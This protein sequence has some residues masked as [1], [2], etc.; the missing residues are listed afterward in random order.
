MLA[1]NSVGD[2]TRQGRGAL[3]PDSNM[4]T[5]LRHCGVALTVLL[6]ATA[7]ERSEPPDVRPPEPDLHGARLVVGSSVD[8]WSLL[9][10]PQGGGLAE[11]RTLSDLSRIVWTGTTELPPAIEAHALSGGTVVLR[12]AEGVVHT[13]DPPS[14]VLIRVGEIDP[15]AVWS[16]DAT[17]GL[18]LS[19]NGSLL[20]ISADGV[21][22]YGLEREVTWAAPADG[23]V[24]VSVAEGTE[25]RALWLLQ[26]DQD[27]PVETG[28]AAVRSPGVVTAWGRRAVLTSSDGRGLAVLTVAPIELAGDVNLG[29]PIRTISTSPSTHEIYVGLD[30]PPR[31]LAVN[32]FNLS[33]RVVAELSVA[34]GAI[35][36]TLFGDGILVEQDDQVVRVPVGGGT[37]TRLGSSWRPDLP[38]GIPGPRVIT[39]RSEDVFVADLQTG[40]ETVLEGAQPD[41][42]WLPVHWNPA[43]T[44]VT[45]DRV[46]GEVV[47]GEVREPEPAS[48]DAGVDSAA[49]AERM[50][51][52]PGL[53]DRAAPQAATGPPPGF[54]AIVGSARQPDGIRS[55][56]QSLED[57]GFATQ[58]QSF[59]DEAGR[60]WYRGLVGPYRSRSEAEAA[61]RQLL[62]ERRLEAWVTEVGAGGRA[63]EETI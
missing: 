15:E 58:I 18:Y 50:R 4:V 55:L 43:Q 13:Y 49:L 62:R 54:Y 21:W 9:S 11:A 63:D 10:V 53:R 60:T 6:L 14:D 34:P 56:V 29:A 25:Q 46:T 44:V 7:C 27:E 48:P 3:K 38:L 39:T 33:S 52:A 1:T 30:D 35:R 8:Q 22:L 61:A 36:P 40:R 17:V 5:R 59:P 41:R 16:G 19:P 51:A 20:E 28:D 2:G 57:A 12:T 32:R 26:R 47:P 24:L 42:W 23:G 31:L 37:P 45:A